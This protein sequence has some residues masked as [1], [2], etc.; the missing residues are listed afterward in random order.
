[1]FSGLYGLNGRQHGDRILPGRL[2]PLLPTQARQ[3]G[4]NAFYFIIVHGLRSGRRIHQFEREHPM[5]DVQNDVFGPGSFAQSVQGQRRPGAS[6]IGPYRE[7]A[8]FRI[9]C[10]H[11]T[12]MPGQWQ[13]Q[14]LHPPGRGAR[15]RNSNH[16]NE[17]TL[18]NWACGVYKAACH[19][20]PFSQVPA[21][22]GA[23]I[24][25]MDTL[26]RNILAELQADGRLTLTDLADRKSTRLNSSHVATSY[27]VFCLKKK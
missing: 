6:D 21:K 18:M 5:I 17:P 23:R 24:C 19:V 9:T 27:A 2:R 13:W 15:E 3:D 20:L 4:N 7:H 8:R 11:N 10:S 12:S 14:T 16:S 25:T 26:D 1:M 22:N